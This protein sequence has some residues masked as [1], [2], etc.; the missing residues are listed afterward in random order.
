[1][2]KTEYKALILRHLLEDEKNDLNGRDIQVFSYESTLPDEPG[3]SHKL[4]PFELSS[5]IK[6]KVN[7][8]IL[9]EINNFTS[10]EKQGE[11]LM[12]RLKFETAYLWY[13]HR[14]RINF[15][16]R[17][18]YYRIEAINELN[19]NNSFITVYTDDKH[20]FDHFINVSTV[21]VILN[22]SASNNVKNSKAGLIGVGITLAFRAAKG[23]FKSK[24]IRSRKNLVLVNSDHGMASYTGKEYYNRYYAN[25][26]KNGNPENYAVLDLRILKKPG[27]SNSSGKEFNNN[28]TNYPV[29]TSEYVILSEG[30]RARKKMPEV[31]KF[32]EGLKELRN[33]WRSELSEIQ[34]QIFDE[35]IK[36]NSSSKLYLFQYLCFK[37][38]FK[39]SS[40]ENIVTISEHSSN[41]RS[42]LDAANSVDIRTIGIQHGIIGP[43]NVSYI[44]NKDEIEFNPL[45]DQTI[46]WGKIWQKYLIEHSCYN[47][48]NT[49]VI[50][51]LRADLIP[52]FNKLNKKE[53]SQEFDENK[54]MILF[55]SQPQKDE[56]LRKQA[57][58]DVFNAT[59]DESD[60]QVIVKTH[61]SEEKG[62]YEAIA[63]E[64]G[65]SN[66]LILGEE[67]DLYELLAVSDVVITCFS[68]VGG[69]AIYFNKPLITIDPTNEDIAGYAAHH[70]SDQVKNASELKQ[71][72]YN[73]VHQQTDRS[74]YYS[75]YIRSHVNKID[76]SVTSDYLK[77]ID[78]SF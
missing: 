78:Q 61:P 75:E 28:T 7:R 67:I 21:D 32:L 51:Q 47:E 70:V 73:A 14:F 20:L 65:A 76:G 10:L 35:L 56:H 69:E 40:I 1:M 9:T 58:L 60:Y 24:R 31:K 23:V 68:T 66:F 18:L 49:V 42:I 43:Y 6:K 41:E 16:L 26:L 64:A 50:G 53:V 3:L 46:V 30:M 12:D 34:L 37:S 11:K 63:K 29:L 38:F 45:P 27:A 59:K 22:T 19:A 72:I 36:L 13:Y 54:S 2:G 77:L 17:E 4:I 15:I 74:V 5:E 44:F 8:E 62:Y 48:E 33:V 25:L 39:G 52:Q 71:S 55:A 57:A